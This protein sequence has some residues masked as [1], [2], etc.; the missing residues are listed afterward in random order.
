MNYS[1]KDRLS[2]NRFLLQVK[3]VYL[4]RGPDGSEVK[5]AAR[6]VLKGL[7]YLRLND[8][9][10][11]VLPSHLIVCRVAS[12]PVLQL[13]SHVLEY[14]HVLGVKQNPVALQKFHQTGRVLYLWNQ[15]VREY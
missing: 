15:L 1:P 10:Y 8:D 6:N 2:L 7:V 5:R 3:V 14:V 9:R 13:V 12:A 4:K 11:L